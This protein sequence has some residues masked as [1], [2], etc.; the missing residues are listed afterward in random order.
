[1]LKNEMKLGFGCMRLPMEGEKIDLAAFS[2][3]IDSFMAAGGRYFDTAHNYIS[4]QSEPAIRKCLVERYPRESYILTTK[5][6]NLYYETAEDVPAIFEKQLKTCGVEYFDFYLCHAMSKA[7]YEK[8][9]RCR[10]F[11]YLQEFKK[12]GRIRH[13]GI[14]FHDTPEVLERILKEQPCI[15]IVQ[16]QFNYA[17]Y[18]N[19][20]VQSMRCYE[21]C[22][23]YGKPVIVMEPV[24]GGKLVDLPKD[25]R[26]V[27]EKLGQGSY[28][29]Y[30]LRYCASFENIVMILSGMS[31]QA[32]MEDNLTTMKEV[33]PLTEKEFDAVAQVRKILRESQQI[34]CT[35]CRY[36]TDVCPQGIAIPRLFAAQN[37]RMC[38]EAWEPVETASPTS[39]ID[40]GACENT[41][42][43]HLPIRKLI[44]T[45]LPV[46]KT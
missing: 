3:M 8:G 36:C 28:A 35:D 13:I 33:K 5:L 30:A 21:V 39:C 43:Q 26:E 10:I 32:Q 46:V 45:A 9:L 22:E 31:D 14:S 15:E 24:K 20:D 23:K 40:C 2:K 18:D 7:R 25:G 29:S 17:D 41:C 4:E 37:A 16:L 11:D 44:K 34:A 6:T 12:Q 1:M 42:P 19:P 27:L 38:L